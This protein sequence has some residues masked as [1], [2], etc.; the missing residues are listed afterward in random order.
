MFTG[1]VEESGRVIDFVEGERS[2]RLRV[3]ANLILEGLS[4]G[5]SVAVN[6]C[7]LTMVELSNDTLMFDVLAETRRLTNLGALASGSL[8]NLERSLAFGGKLGGHFVTG[9]IDGPGKILEF[10]RRGSDYFLRVSVPSGYNR[11]VIHKGSI[12]I[13]GI[14]LTVAELD[15]HSLSVWLIPHTLTVTNLRDRAVGQQ[16]NLEFDLLGKY[17]EKLLGDRATTPVG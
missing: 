6:G 15:E 1:I 3:A 5:D 2:S 9:H 14:S 7:C 8:V 12:A 11:Y 17:V 4:L 10:E 13:D 16:V